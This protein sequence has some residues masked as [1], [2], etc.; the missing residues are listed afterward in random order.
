MGDKSR[1][2]GGSGLGLPLTKKIV[3]KASGR[4]YFER[5][6]RKTTFFVELPVEYVD[7]A[8]KNR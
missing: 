1:R 5:D 3:E 7:M 8:E 4:I 2:S 6:N